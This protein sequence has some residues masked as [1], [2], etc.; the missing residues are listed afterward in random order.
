MGVCESRMPWSDDVQD[1]IKRLWH[2]RRTPFEPD[3]DECAMRLL[4]AYWRVLLP[5]L[6]FQ[7]VGPA[8]GSIGFQGKDPATDVRAGG[9]LSVM[10]IEHFASFYTLGV[11]QMLIDLRRLERQEGSAERFYPLS[12]A[13][14]VICAMLCD[15]IGISDGMRGPISEKEL[16][17][18]L[19]RAPKLAMC[20]LLTKEGPHVGFQ[21]LFSFALAHFHVEFLRRGLG[22]LQC[23]Q[24]AE[25]VV[26]QLE[27]RALTFPTLDSLR[28]EYCRSSPPVGQLLV[29]AGG[30]ACG[31]RLA[32]G[33]TFAARAQQGC[34]LQ[35]IVADMQ[36]KSQADRSTKDLRWNG[37]EYE[38][39]TGMWTKMSHV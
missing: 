32:R 17:Q 23:R 13:A 14:I 18:L 6:S 36:G 28:Q 38:V 35:G 37:T 22:Y 29:R 5:T 12:T 3:T 27:A 11:R 24:C 15:R 30:E 31:W 26:D 10:C 34:T 20:S 7:R 9:L 4:R 19:A 1:E 16:D 33:V 8:W 2:A 21:E 25:D 39:S